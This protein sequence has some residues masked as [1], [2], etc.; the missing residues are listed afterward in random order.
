ME[1]DEFVWLIKNRILEKFHHRRDIALKHYE[2][3]VLKGIG[4][5]TELDFKAGCSRGILG[6]EDLIDKILI[7]TS[8]KPKQKIKLP[9]LISKVCEMYGLN[10]EELRKPGKQSW[11]SQARALIAFL[12]REIDTLSFEE[13][14]QYLDRDS[15][16]LSKLA[17]RM[18]TKIPKDIRITQNIKIMRRWLSEFLEE[19]MSE[20]QA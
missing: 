12:V 8:S 9:D 14:G 5:E 6:N 1:L 2:H 15:S 4:I 16:G 20:C 19:R 17:A 18:S 13:L 3:F 10:H 11:P 7:K